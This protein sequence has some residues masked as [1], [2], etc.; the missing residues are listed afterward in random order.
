ML[1]FIKIFF[2]KPHRPIFTLYYAQKIKSKNSYII[3]NIIAI[4][5]LK[6]ILNNT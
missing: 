2:K 5:V 6:T 4:L 3:V 1:Y